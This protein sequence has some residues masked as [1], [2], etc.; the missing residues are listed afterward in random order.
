VVL[1]LKRGWYFFLDLKK[2]GILKKYVSKI[3]VQQ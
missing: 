3:N 2:Y 1:L